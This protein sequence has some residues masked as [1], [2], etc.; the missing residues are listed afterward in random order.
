MRN[1]TS[2]AIGAALAAAALIATV[3]TVSAENAVKAEG[4]VTTEDV[5]AAELVTEFDTSRTPE[6]GGIA[7]PLAA[8]NVAASG[9]PTKLRKPLWVWVKGSLH[10]RSEALYRSV[11][12]KT[13]AWVTEGPKATD[14]RVEVDNLEAS[15]SEVCDGTK[16]RAWA[17]EDYNGFKFFRRQ[18]GLPRPGSGFCFPRKVCWIGC[19]TENG[20]RWCA[21][22]KECPRG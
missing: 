10:T 7:A 18:R 22:T 3:S 4:E 6:L 13:W 17:N 12:I 1:S 14:P 19:A 15:F 5:P 21:K 20:F 9:A 11:E 16:S 8:E 2:W